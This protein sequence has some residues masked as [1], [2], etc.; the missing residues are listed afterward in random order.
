MNHRTKIVVASVLA[1]AGAGPA[2]AT[3]SSKMN[4]HPQT[5]HARSHD[6]MNARAYAPDDAALDARAYAPN[7]A[8][9]GIGP[10]FSIGSQR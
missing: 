10:D 1:L 4:Q 8:P 9:I 3:H 6:A 7:D 2:F 5:E